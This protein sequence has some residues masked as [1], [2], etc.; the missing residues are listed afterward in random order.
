MRLTEETAVDLR[1]GNKKTGT[2]TNAQNIAN[3]ETTWQRDQLLEPRRLSDIVDY[4]CFL[5]GH[6][7]RC[8]TISNCKKEESRRRVIRSLS[9]CLEFD[10]RLCICSFWEICL[11]TSCIFGSLVDSLSSC[12]W[13]I[14][15]LSNWQETTFHL[16]VMQK[17]VIYCLLQ[18]LLCI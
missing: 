9:C 2:M 16:F 11:S 14:E 6:T 18:G 3:E 7:L 13:D 5:H 12:F 8:E 1:S 4:F 15:K 10:I 17:K